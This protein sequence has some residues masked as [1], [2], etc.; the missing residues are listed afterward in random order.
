MKTA[1]V[2]GATG[3]VGKEL[4]RLLLADNRFAKVIVFAR[5]SL[6]VKHV[7]LEEHLIDFNNTQ[8]WT[9]LVKAD[10]LFSTLGTTLKQAGGKEAQYKVDY[11]YQFEFAKAA[12]LN[13]VP[14]YVLVSSSGANPRSRIFYSRMKGELEDAVRKLNFSSTSLIRP[15]LLAGQRQEERM[16]EKIGY[17]LL[18]TFNA[19]GILK[20]YRPIQG[21]IVARAMINAATEAKRGV[22]IYELEEVFTLAA[23]N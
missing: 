12:A 2:I 5:R 3:L 17:R 23:V 15:G 9:Q 21:E 14:V 11:T 19:L 16:G 22:H 8:N 1:A 20:R 7:K 13:Q 6:M 10:V 4:V 18:N